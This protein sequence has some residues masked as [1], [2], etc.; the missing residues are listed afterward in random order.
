MR[1]NVGE[2][3]GQLLGA[4]SLDRPF[5][6]HILLRWNLPQAAAA[7]AIEAIQAVVADAPLEVLERSKTIVGTLPLRDVARIAEMPSVF[8]IDLDHQ[9]PLES[10]LDKS[11]R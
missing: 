6:V 3:L 11:A 5:R 10:L 8:W 1:T 9:A 4:D 7:A 2:R